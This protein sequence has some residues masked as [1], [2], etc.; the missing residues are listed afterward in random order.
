MPWEYAAGPDGSFLA[1]DYG[2]L[3]LL[4]YVRPA[5]PAAAAPLNFIALAADPLVQ[6]DQARTPRTGY[7]LDIETRAAS[8]RPG[9]A[10]ERRRVDRPAH[11]A[12]R[13]SPARR[14]APRARGAAPELSRRS[15]R[16]QTAGG[17]NGRQAVLILEDKDGMAAPLRGATFTAMPPPGVLRLV[18]LSACRTAASAM[19]AQFGPNLV[20][21]GVPTAIGMQGDFPDPLS[22]DLAAACTISCWRATRWARRCARRGWRWPTGPT[23][24]GCP[25]PTWRAGGDAPLPIQPGPARGGRSGRGPLRQRA[26]EPAAARPFVGREAELHGLARAFNDGRSGS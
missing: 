18:V 20:L 13:G 22:D 14:A 24:W 4:P 12:D 6:N 26:A 10:G 25:W 3:R 1:C 21:A 17:K 2:F 9:A 11:S 19:D 23:P 5:R 16:G 7:K 8:H 15:D